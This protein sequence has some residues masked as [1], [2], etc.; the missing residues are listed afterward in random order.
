MGVPI[1][2]PSVPEPADLSQR[3]PKR[4]RLSDTTSHF[5]NPRSRSRIRPRRTYDPSAF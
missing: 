4:Y 2:R 1:W 5:V 3:A